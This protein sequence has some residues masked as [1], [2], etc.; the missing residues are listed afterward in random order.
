MATCAHH[1]CCCGRTRTAAEFLVLGRLTEGEPTVLCERY[2]L[3]LILAWRAAV[4]SLSLLLP[5]V[6]VESSMVEFC[7]WEAKKKSGRVVYQQW[8]IAL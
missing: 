4:S 5:V 8:M 3:I 7:P 6:L 1:L 2:F